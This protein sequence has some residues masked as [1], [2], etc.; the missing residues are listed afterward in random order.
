MKT[1][2]PK[3]G[4]QGALYYAAIYPDGIIAVAL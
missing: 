4:R 1:Q 2:L 3:A